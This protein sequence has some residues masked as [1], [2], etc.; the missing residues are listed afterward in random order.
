MDK[1]VILETKCQETS[2]SKLVNQVHL[3][4]FFLIPWRISALLISAQS[5]RHWAQKK[6][7]KKEKKYLTLTWSND[8]FQ[9]KNSSPISG[10]S[11]GRLIF[12]EQQVWVSLLSTA[13]PVSGPRP[14]RSGPCCPCRPAHL[15]DCHQPPHTTRGALHK[16][17][18]WKDLHRS[19]FLV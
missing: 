1:M 19:C 10:G 4:T 5:F 12:L 18:N 7:R 9:W 16:S 15:T 2:N 14:C 8:W 11:D 17:T 3:F 6:K 13:P